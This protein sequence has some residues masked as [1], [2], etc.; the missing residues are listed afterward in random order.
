MLVI[1]PLTLPR[2]RFEATQE[3]GLG[4]QGVACHRSF[5]TLGPFL[6]AGS[7]LLCRLAGRRD[8]LELGH[9]RAGFQYVPMV[10][11]RG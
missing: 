5:L 6:H 11:D 8:N 3:L 10:D 9:C 1:L 7:R 4:L 2:A